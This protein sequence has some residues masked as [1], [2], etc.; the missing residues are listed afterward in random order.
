MLVVSLVGIALAVM[1]GFLVFGAAIAAW[2]FFGAFLL[3]SA[4]LLAVGWVY[5]RRRAGTRDLPDI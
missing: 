3:L 1:I 5:D 2:G 4:V